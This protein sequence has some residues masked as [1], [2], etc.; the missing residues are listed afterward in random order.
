MRAYT[1]NELFRL[2]RYDLLALQ[3]EIAVQ[4]SD[5]SESERFVALE[6]LRLLRIVLARQRPAPS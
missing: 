1:L 3:A 2:T 4:L 6:N 5:P